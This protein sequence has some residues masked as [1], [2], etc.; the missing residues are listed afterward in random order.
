MNVYI[1]DLY[2]NF[3]HIIDKHNRH[4]I[5]RY[6]HLWIICCQCQR[7]CLGCWNSIH[8]LHYSPFWALAS[9]RRWCLHASLFSVRHLHPRNPRICDVFLRTTFAHLVLG[10]PTDLLLWNFPL[11]IFWGILSSSSLTICPA[12]PSLLILI[13]STIFRSLYKL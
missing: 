11:R 6:V 7:V 13:S 2:W 10:Y 12:H 9:L 4:C 8:L 5:K 3:V 1:R